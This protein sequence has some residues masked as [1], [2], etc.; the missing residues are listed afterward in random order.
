MA[1]NLDYL[2]PNLLP[3]EEKVTA[4]LAAEEE[5]RQLTVATRSHAAEVAQPAPDT[6]G[7]EQRPPT[8]S[9]DQTADELTLKQQNLQDALGTLRQDILSLLPARDEWVK[10][11]LGYGPSRVGAFRDESSP[12]D[13]PQYLIR[14]VH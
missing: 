10:V 1:S 11:N 4:Y 14:V 13:A 6:G 3:L 9:F 8:G 2:D 5:L 7:F 12:A